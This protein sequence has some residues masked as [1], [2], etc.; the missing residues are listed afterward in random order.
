MKQ[1]TIIS[2]KGGAGKTTITASLLSFIRDPVVVDCDV[3]ASNLHLLLDPGIL[4]K[5]DFQG[6]DVARINEDLCDKCGNCSQICRFQAI[7]KDMKIEA[8][9]CEGCAVCTLVCPRDA[10]SMEPRIS[11][12]AFISNTRFGP[13]VH[14]K[15]RPGEEASG[16]LVSHV[17]TKAIDIARNENKETILIDGPPGSGC[18]VIASITGV[19]LV[20][21]VVEPTLSSIHDAKR[22]MELCDHFRIKPIVCI[23]KFDINMENTEKI[24]YLCREK[25]IEVVGKIPYDERVTKAMVSKRTLTEY[26][27]GE[28][29]RIIEEI[30]KKVKKELE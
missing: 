13:L 5:E 22:A 4:Q 17:R 1:V 2:G 19:N 7:S 27:D 15:L 21:I 9:R 18:E 26:C 29:Y 24:L 8:D 11:G 20:V 10:I 14:A 12:E 23:N 30:W 6:L 28:L 3:D 25:D 16:K